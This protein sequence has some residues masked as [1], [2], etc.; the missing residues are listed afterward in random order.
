MKS[1]STGLEPNIMNMISINGMI[2]AKYLDNQVGLLSK[3]TIEEW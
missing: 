3:D 1:A 2:M